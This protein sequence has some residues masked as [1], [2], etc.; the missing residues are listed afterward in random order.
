MKHM[1]NVPVPLK[2]QIFRDFNP[3]VRTDLLALHFQLS[4]IDFLLLVNA[5]SA[6][7]F[8]QSITPQEVVDEHMEALVL[9]DFNATSEFELEV[10]G[11]SPVYIALNGKSGNTHVW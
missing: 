6:S 5:S 2:V 11:G 3:Q 1:G 10:R 9:F 8:V 4:P 7:A